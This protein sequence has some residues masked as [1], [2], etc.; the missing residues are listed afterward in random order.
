VE[1]G[2]ETLEPWIEVRSES[3]EKELDVRESQLEHAGETAHAK[4]R[5]ELLGRVGIGFDRRQERVCGARRGRVPSTT[6]EKQVDLL[7]GDVQAA[8]AIVRSRVT[9]PAGVDCR[10]DTC[11]DHLQATV[12]VREGGIRHVHSR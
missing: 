9:S 6:T 3:D 2:E 8:K 11:F 7:V 12:E 1:I 5:T 4:V 10:A